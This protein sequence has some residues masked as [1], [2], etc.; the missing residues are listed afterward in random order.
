LL[1]I[2]NTAA[3]APWTDGSRHFIVSA[4]PANN[5]GLLPSLAAHPSQCPSAGPAGVIAHQAMVVAEMKPDRQAA[6][7]DLAR[8][9]HELQLEI[10][11]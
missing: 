7:S 9:R 11:S 10:R 5:P 6:Q 2:R 4:T 8:L 3:T 1:H